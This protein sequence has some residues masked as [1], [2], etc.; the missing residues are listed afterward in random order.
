MVY[1]LLLVSLRPLRDARA[2][3]PS[4]VQ[5]PRLPLGNL[6]VVEL[7]TPENVLPDV[8]WEALYVLEVGDDDDYIVFGTLGLDQLQRFGRI[9]GVAGLRPEHLVVL[10]W[11]SQCLG[12]DITASLSAR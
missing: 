11:A 2:G 8:G 5:E 12:H 1:F 3:F 9:F 7:H 6:D 4:E 10:D